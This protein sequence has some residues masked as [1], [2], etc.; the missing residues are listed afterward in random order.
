MRSTGWTLIAVCALVVAICGARLGAAGGD[1]KDDPPGEPSC[2]AM[3][4]RGDYG[5]QF[6]GTRPAPGGSMET[7]I[8]VVHRTY[9]G[10][11]N[12][13]QVDN[14]KGSVTGITPDRR[15]FGTYEVFADCTGIAR[16][17]PGP[18]IL[19]EERMVIVDHGREIRTITASPAAVMVTSVQRRI[20]TR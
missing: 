3:T 18:G 11:G 16:F 9:D 1:R 19:I 8:G 20:D 10:E 14:V 5:I 12:V 6:Q 13:D 7:V 15:G 2:S 17:Q 4:I